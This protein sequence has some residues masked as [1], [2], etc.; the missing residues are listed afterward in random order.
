MTG[1]MTALEMKA[2]LIN[3]I[4]GINDESVIN[5][6][7]RYVSKLIKEAKKDRI[8]REDLF[9]DPEV[10]S[11]VKDIKGGPVIDDKEA[12]HAHWEEKYK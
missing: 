6:I 8:R 11:W 10:A 7:S 3:S 1:L 5:R 9:I 12:M 2:S 4:E